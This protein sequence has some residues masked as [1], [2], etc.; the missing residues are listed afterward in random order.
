MSLVYDSRKGR[1]PDV[2]NDRQTQDHVQTLYSFE[3]KHI[4]HLTNSSEG[5][6]DGER[7]FEVRSQQ[8]AYKAGWFY[9]VPTM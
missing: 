5:V 6:K 7:D 1:G 4:P 3:T 8:Q 9:S 2:G